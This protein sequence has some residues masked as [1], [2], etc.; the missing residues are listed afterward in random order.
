[1]SECQ[2]TMEFETEVANDAGITKLSLFFVTFL[3]FI[4]KWI[5]NAVIV[6]G[7]QKVNSKST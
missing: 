4:G 1:M 2:Y 7:Q 5:E 3:Y 6:S